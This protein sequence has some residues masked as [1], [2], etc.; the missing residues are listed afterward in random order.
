MEAT[1][2]LWGVATLAAVS[3]LS[4][5]ILGR[6]LPLLGTILIGAW[7]LSRQYLFYQATTTL[8]SELTVKQ[9]PARTLVR[10]DQTVAVTLTA[11]VSQPTALACTIT[12]GLPT[13]A[14]S[15]EQPRL[16]L[17]PGETATETTVDIDWPVAGQH[18]FQQAT[19]TVED[20]LFEQTVPVGETVTVTVQPRGPRDIH[21][22]EGGDQALLAYGEHAADHPG[23]GVEPAELREYTTG[24]AADRI[25]WNATARLNTPYIR[26]F[27]AETDQETLLV[28]DHRSQLSTGPPAETK[29]A[30]LREV[31]LA[32]VDGTK[33]RNDPLGMVSV[34]DDGITAQFEPTTTA[35]QYDAL[36]RTLLTLE[37]T[38][39]HPTGT[40]STTGLSNVSTVRQT[41][42]G[43]R[44]SLTALGLDDD[45]F[46]TTLRP[47]Y[48]TQQHYQR[49]LEDRPLTGAVRAA[50]TQR[51]GQ[52][53]TLICT[54][55]SAPRELRE[56]ATVAA[57]NGGQVVLLLA[58]T[59]LYETG[60]VEALEARYEQYVAFEEFRR[61]LSRL[62]R[63]TALEVGPGDRL[64]AILDAGGRYSPTGGER[65]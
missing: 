3:G 55:D 32:L 21:V 39:S 56:T 46:G 16:I 22:G 35:S 26:E 9:Q 54:D 61:E 64:T 45:A 14:S 41:M 6:L 58:P 44:A 30:Y 59:V 11:T 7:L 17:T 51:T 8:V 37:P 20:G 62:D 29:L 60:T 38:T 28:I 5:A 12:A 34:G 15:S 27:E 31:A 36:R 47:F 40:D 4:A 1:R 52:Q 18:D 50:L 25:D 24:D 2:R 53:M 10:T 48:E 13:A 19:L 43:V 49:V 65:A 23:S 63:V 42:G 33:Q 57:Q